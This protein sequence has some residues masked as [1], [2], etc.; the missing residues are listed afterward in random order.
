MDSLADMATRQTNVQ[1]RHRAGAARGHRTPSRTGPG[2]A[3]PAAPCAARRA[4]DPGRQAAY[5]PGG[6]SPIGVADLE[7]ARRQAGVELAAGDIILLH[8]DFAAWYVQ[9]SRQVKNRLHSN[10]VAPGLEHTEAI[11]EYLWNSHAAGVASD[12]FGVEVF[13]P[14][15]A[16][17]APVRVLHNMLIGQLGMALGELSWL[18][19]LAGDCAADGVYEMFGSAPR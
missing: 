14:T 6:N 1:R 5:D 17:G 2:K 19:D 11:C 4:G 10:V 9:Q 12:T 7:L 13:R 16:A 8:T 18:S 15:P 3:W